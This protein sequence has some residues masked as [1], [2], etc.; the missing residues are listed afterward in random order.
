MSAPRAENLSATMASA[1]SARR[2]QV[3]IGKG[4]QGSGLSAF[5]TELLCLV[6]TLAQTGAYVGLTVH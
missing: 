4:L 5:S 1:I 3:V 6:A 2:Q